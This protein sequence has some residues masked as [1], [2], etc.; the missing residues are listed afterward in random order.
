MVGEMKR[1]NDE[2]LNRRI[3]IKAKTEFVHAPDQ[4]LMILPITRPAR[5]SASFLLEFLERLP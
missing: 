2:A 5:P 4:R 1:R 3:E